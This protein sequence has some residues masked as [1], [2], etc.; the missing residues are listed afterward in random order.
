MRRDTRAAGASPAA[1]SCAAAARARRY[2]GGVAKEPNKP[3]PP[4]PELAALRARAAEIK[5]RS[6]QLAQE[7]A[8]LS[9]KIEARLNAQRMRG[10]DWS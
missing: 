8:E 3:R 7:M 9:A 1:F 4:D 10:R 6:A 2:D 5:R